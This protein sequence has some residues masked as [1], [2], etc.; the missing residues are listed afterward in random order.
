MSVKCLTI[1]VYMAHS[2][3]QRQ[4]NMNNVDHHYYYCNDGCWITIYNFPMQL[5]DKWEGCCWHAEYARFLPCFG[6]FN[7]FNRM[8]FISAAL[9]FCPLFA[10]IFFLCLVQLH[11]HFSRKKNKYLHITSYFNCFLWKRK[12]TNIQNY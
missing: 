6:I 3:E 4:H 1:S 11:V 7:I 12:C 5:S 2:R 8:F 9:V 10:H